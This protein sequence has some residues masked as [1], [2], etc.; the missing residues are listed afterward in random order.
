M[1]ACRRIMRHLWL[2]LALTPLPAW[3]GA[4]GAAF[5]YVTNSAG[6]SIHVIDPA[7]NKVVQEIKGVEAAHASHPLPTARGSTSATRPTA[8]STCSIALAAR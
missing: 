2:V 1:V 7:T 5:I 4:E 6:D 8:R 3:G